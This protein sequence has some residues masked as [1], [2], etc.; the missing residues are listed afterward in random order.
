MT[1]HRR[2]EQLEDITYYMEATAADGKSVAVCKL[3]AQALTGNSGKEAQ[4]V[5]ASGKDVAQELQPC[6]EV[7]SEK[8]AKADD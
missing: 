6:G 4:S 7:P 5:V 1:P 2:Q 3:L 8:E